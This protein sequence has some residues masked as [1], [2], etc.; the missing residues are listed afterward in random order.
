M[1]ADSLRGSSGHVE[2]ARASLG[3]RDRSVVGEFLVRVTSYR[4]AAVLCG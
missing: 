1:S 2:P 4:P 3:A